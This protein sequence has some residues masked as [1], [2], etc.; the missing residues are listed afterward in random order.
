MNLK[1]NILLLFLLCFAAATVRA[2]LQPFTVLS[3]NSDTAN[4]YLYVE[5]MYQKPA[6][7]DYQA[8][9]TWVDKSGAPWH[10]LEI[11][12]VENNAGTYQLSADRTRLMRPKAGGYRLRFKLEE[13]AKM[14]EGL[15]LVVESQR[16]PYECVGCGS[17]GSTVI[18]E[19]RHVDVDNCPNGFGLREDVVACHMRKGVTQNWEAWI[20]DSR[21]CKPYRVVHMPD[22][23]WW[24]AQNL[25]YQEE[26]DLQATASGGG[27][28]AGS[29]WCPG[30]YSTN[31]SGGSDACKT[32]GALYTWEAMMSK[33]NGRK[34]GA[35]DLENAVGLGQPSTVRGICPE[36][37]Y[38]PS[39][40]DWA[41]MLNAVEAQVQSPND[42]IN[43]DD[44]SAMG[45]KGYAAAKYL[46]SSM[47]CAA[48][49][50]AASPVAGLQAACA[51]AAMPAWTYYLDYVKMLGST[52]FA[53]DIYGFGLLAAGRRNADVGFDR[54]RGTDALIWTSSEASVTEGATR[55]FSAAYNSVAYGKADKEK[56]AYGVRCMAR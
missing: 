36:G 20:V 3:N 24:F 30:E 19:A 16:L 37:W 4:N 26:L 33:F 9:F 13:G 2:Q 53:Y 27:D 55:E 18:F 41:Q 39:F 52:R 35:A 56:M 5:L 11:D 40:Y 21:D 25:N 49:D 15:K 47:H 50:L 44:Y 23:T 10:D 1:F 6:C 12:R 22:G 8:M 7:G 42:S 43:H 34:A 38:V 54:V 17:A 45:S 32:Y 14:G 48:P 29:Y 46:K 51:T 28:G 31:T